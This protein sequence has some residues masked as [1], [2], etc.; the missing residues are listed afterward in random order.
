[1]DDRRTRFEAEVLPHLDAAYRFAR[2][3]AYSPAD[4]QDV[5]QDAL[6]RAYRSFDA[7]RGSDAKAWLLVIVRNCHFTAA[8]Q[9]QRRAAVP[10]PEEIDLEDDPAMISQD[11]GPEAATMRRDEARTLGRLIAALPED[12]RTVLMLREMEGMDYAQIAMITNA[13]I[14]TVMSR[15]ARSRAA[16]KARWLSESKESPHA[17]R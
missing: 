7:L 3:L 17:M 2:W 10:L 5:V 1:M 11:P 8:K 9:R 14:G 12:Q 6:L 13:P 15:L 16:L 4:A